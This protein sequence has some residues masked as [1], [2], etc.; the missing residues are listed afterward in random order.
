MTARVAI[1]SNCLRIELTAKGHEE[2]FRVLKIGHI[3]NVIPV[4][5]LH[6]IATINK[7][8]KLVNFL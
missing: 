6:I 7:T 2:F 3:L 1:A 5:Q 8:I 4:T